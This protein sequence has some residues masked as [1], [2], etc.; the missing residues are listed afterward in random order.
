MTT[1]VTR[2]LVRK[3]ADAL[4]NDGAHPRPFDI[5]R[6][7]SGPPQQLP[8]DIHGVT[9]PPIRQAEP[10]LSAKSAA[11][12]TR[13]SPGIRGEEGINGRDCMRL[14]QLIA[15]GS[16]RIEAIQDFRRIISKYP[17]N[18]ELLRIYAARLAADNRTEDA[19]WAF[20]RAAT[21]FFGAGTHFK[22]WLCKLLEWR[23]Q[24][25]S[26]EQL[27]EVQ[28][29]IMSAS[30]QTG[31]DEFVQ[32]LTSAERLAIFSKVKFVSVPAGKSIL[33]AEEGRQGLYVVI[34][35]VL[36]EEG[37]GDGSKPRIY[38]ETNCFGFTAPPSACHPGVRSMTRAELMAISR[39]H[40]L[41]TFRRFPNAERKLKLLYRPP[42]GKGKRPVA[43]QRT[44]KGERYLNR[45]FMSLR[46]P[47]L[48]AGGKSLV[49][50]GFSHEI[51]LTGISFIPE[52]HGRPDTSDIIQNAASFIGRKV[53][54]GI[55]AEGISVEVQGQVVRVNEVLNNGDRVF[56]F[57]IQF[58]EVSPLVR[59]MLFTFAAN[60]GVDLPTRAQ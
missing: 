11:G 22:G 29:T 60:A 27:T 42:E 55:L 37:P 26:G 16:I 28:K 33:P 10:N 34:A 49:L 13:P 58:A 5:F 35:G 6:K 31:V 7:M 39:E 9:A 43:P 15:N 23:L 12:G 47:P 51:S 40:L 2:A 4:C 45:T 52:Q 57:S 25:P 36:K 24:R 50:K 1:R 30:P 46:I 18:P 41:S 44:R 8:A 48:Q 38:Q 59:W 3:Q 54:A 14:L 56:C 19:A 17:E 21:L 32:Q 53:Y 20:A